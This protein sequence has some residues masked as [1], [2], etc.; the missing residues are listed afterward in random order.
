M[1]VPDITPEDAPVPEGW[2]EAGY[3][4]EDWVQWRAEKR[5]MELRWAEHAPGPGFEDEVL[6]LLRAIDEKLGRLL[7]GRRP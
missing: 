2:I 6:A 3:T 7:E 1:T 4:E 5:S